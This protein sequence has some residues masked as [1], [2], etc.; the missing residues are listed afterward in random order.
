MMYDPAKQAQDDVSAELCYDIT[1]IVTAHREGLLSHRTVRSIQAA[2]E[3]A[4]SRGYRCEVI[5]L[6]DNADAETTQYYQSLDWEPLRTIATNFRDPGP[7]R[8]LGARE[9]R[10]RYVAFLDGDD[11]LGRRWLEV[12]VECLMQQPGPAVAVPECTA[13]FEE[14]WLNSVHHGSSDP[15]FAIHCLVEWNYWN[16]VLLMTERSV[17]LK[18]PFSLAPASSGFAYEDW[19][20]FCEVL[21]EGIPIIAAKEGCAFV[22]RKRRESRL[23]SYVSRDTLLPPARLFQPHEFSAIAEKFSLSHPSAEQGNPKQGFRQVVSGALAG[24]GRGIYNFACKTVRQFPVL[25]KPAVLTYRILCRLSQGVI[26]STEMPAWLA[27]EWHLIHQIEPQLAPNPETQVPCKPNWQSMSPVGDAYLQLC[28]EIKAKFTHVVLV[29]WLKRGGSD[30]ETLNYVDAL[31][32]TSDENRVVVLGTDDADS[33]WAERLNPKATFVNFHKFAAPLT[34]EQRERLLVFFLVQAQPEVIHNMNSRLGYDVFRRFGLAL[35]EKSKLYVSVFC[36]DKN[37]QGYTVGYTASELPRCLE[38]LTG[39]MADNQRVLD[40]LHELYAIP[41]EKLH[42]HYQPVELH[43]HEPRA[44]RVEG[45]LH[46]LWAA[47][48]DRQKRPDVLREI[49]RR[50]QDL[51]FHFHVYGSAILRGEA[52]QVSFRNMPN[53]TYHG[54]FDGFQTL[55][56]EKYDVFLS[57]A[58]WEGLPNALLDAAAACMPIVASD[59]GGVSEL[60]EHEEHGLLVSPFDDAQQYVEALKQLHH[61]WTRA[62]SLAEQAHKQVARQHSWTAFT[63]AVLALPGYV[64]VPCEPLA[65]KV[66]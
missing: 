25:Q 12:A 63:D 11:L 51:P 46:I 26:R 27:Q 53:V 55:P 9:A 36:E 49:A 66:A 5:V 65:K 2:V 61:D 10:G 13:V 42:V 23:L 16:S 18:L 3:Q 54:P 21:Y 60:I 48:L 19:H 50:C 38:Y 58:Q 56:I 37:E 24:V 47:R 62:Q 28:R 64:D 44:R 17:A 39:V 31:C 41:Y 34:D 59:V 52:A 57:T 22:R 7:A 15:D 6:L 20:W 43:R 29:P 8:N 32:N 45:E 1:L 35:S 14:E 33:P 30:L 4:E 40:R